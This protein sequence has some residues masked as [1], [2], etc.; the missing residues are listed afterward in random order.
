MMSSNAKIYISQQEQQLMC[1]PEWILTKR[2]VIEK[3]Q[4]MMGELSPD[5]LLLVKNA[6]FLAKE[7]AASIPKIS[8]GENYLGLPYIILDQPA[9]FRGQDIFAIRTMFWWGHFFSVTLQLAGSYKMNFQQI[10]I[11]KLTAGEL[12]KDLFICINENQWEHHFKQDNY[13]AIDELS[14]SEIENI[15]TSGTFIKLA[16]KFPLEQWAIAGKLITAQVGNFIN[17]LKP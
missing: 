2:R 8:K 12:T 5:I 17:L 13:R 6:N 9:F 15:L 1:D 4:I 14:F 16:A 10:L 3:V 7:P 11:N